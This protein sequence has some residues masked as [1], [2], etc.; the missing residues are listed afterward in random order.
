MSV[1]VTESSRLIPLLKP[2][3]SCTI[4]RELHNLCGANIIF[5]V[6]ALQWHHCVFVDSCG[7]SCGA[8]TC[9]GDMA[10]CAV[11]AHTK[12]TLSCT[13]IGV[14]QFLH[15]TAIPDKHVA[16]G[17]HNFITDRAAAF[18]LLSYVMSITSDETTDDELLDL[19]SC[20]RSEPC[21]EASGF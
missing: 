13:Y 17:F 9:L 5:S 16:C 10:F 1:D 18:A 8:Y 20:H 21:R 11:N 3:V 2:L 6:M 15:V 19:L 7:S 4:S 12:S 14:M